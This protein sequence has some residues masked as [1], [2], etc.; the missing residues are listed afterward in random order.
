MSKTNYRSVEYLMKN[1]RKQNKTNNDQ[2]KT[3]KNNNNTPPKKKTTTKKKKTKNKKQRKRSRYG[4]LAPASKFCK[5]SAVLLN[6]C[7]FSM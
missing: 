5:I 3:T 6:R 4:N 7:C 1:K 2:K